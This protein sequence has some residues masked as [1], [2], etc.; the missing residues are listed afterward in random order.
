MSYNVYSVGFMAALKEA[1]DFEEIS[2][3]LYDNYDVMVNYDGT[4]VYT[5]DNLPLEEAFGL[6]F[7]KVNE[8]ELE[9]FKSECLSANLFIDEDTITPYSC[10]W[11]NGVDP[12]MSTITLEEFKNGDSR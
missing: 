2:D 8:K 3:N 6:H 1:V 5:H 4:I 7:L 12:D 10:M 9:E 11:Y